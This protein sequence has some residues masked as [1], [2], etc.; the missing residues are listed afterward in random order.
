MDDT[1]LVEP[2]IGVRPWISTEVSEQCTRAA[3]GKL[4]INK[5]KDEVEGEMEHRKLIWGLTYDTRTLPRSL[6]P[7]KLEKA[8]HLLHLPEFDFGNQKIP[9]KLVQELRG[10]QQFWLTVLPSLAPLLSATNALL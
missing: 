9:L 10:N 8:A 6:P 3:L 4:S 1:V 5:S 2:S 7:V